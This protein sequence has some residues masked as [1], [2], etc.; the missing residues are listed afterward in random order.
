MFRERET[1]PA[2]EMYRKLKRYENCIITEDEPLVSWAFFIWNFV[3]RCRMTRFAS[4]ATLRKMKKRLKLKKL[5]VEN[6]A[7]TS[8]FL[9][10]K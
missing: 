1:H 10:I 6:V 8:R 9:E 5:S 3:W 4:S 7:D 2:D